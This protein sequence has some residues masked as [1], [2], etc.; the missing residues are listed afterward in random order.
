MCKRTMYTGDRLNEISFPLGG[1]GTGSIGLGGNGRLMD[2]EIFNHPDKGS[3]NGYSH[4]AVK[5]ERDGKVIDARVLNGDVAGALAA[6]GWGVDKRTLAGFPHFRNC[7]FE[8]EFPLATVTLSDPESPLKAQIHA[9]NPFI[10]HHA[11]DSSIPAAF[12]VVTVTNDSQEPLTVS[13]AGSLQNPYHGAINRYFAEN[14]VKGISLTGV[15]ENRESPDY[16]EIVLAT[17]AQDISYQEYWYRGGW[18][19]FLETY[20]RNFTEA[21]PFHNRTYE[22]DLKETRDHATLCARKTLAAGESYSVRYLIA[23]YN[24]IKPDQW[25]QGEEPDQNVHNY[26]SFVYDG[27]KSVALDCFARWDALYA[28]TRRWHDALFASTL[29]EEVLDAVSATSSVLKT[30]TA[31]RID[32]E[33]WFYGWEGLGQKTGSCEGTCTHVWN[34]A[35]VLPFL[36]PD[37][38]RGIREMDFRYNQKP[39]GEMCFRMRIPLGRGIGEHRACVDGQMGGVMKT[40]REWKLSGDTEWLRSVWAPMKKS[41]EYAWNPENLDKWDSGC[42]GVMDGRQHH[43]LDMELFSPSSWLQ[44]F[45]LGALKAAAEMADALG[46]GDAAKYRQ[47]FEQGKKW[48]AENL[49]NGRYFIQK[50]DLTDKN[51]VER[52]GEEAVS[53]YWNE[54]VGQVKYQYGEGCEIDQMVAQWHADIIGLGDLFDPKQV[55]VALQN[56]FRYNFKKDMRHH[57]NTFRLFAINDES[58]AIICEWPEDVVKPAI[59]TTYAQESMH[60]FEYSFAGLLISRGYVQEGLQVV[61]GVRDRYRGDHRNP[62]NEI[63]CGSNYARSMASFALLPLLSGMTFDMVKGELGFKPVLPGDFRCVWSVG[64]AWGNV[65]IGA[66]NELEI[67]EGELCLNSLTLPVTEV[68][69]VLVDGKAVPFTVADGKITFAEKLC[70]REKLQVL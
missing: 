64:N 13:V 9:F 29:P 59:P 60:G 45:Y 3:L 70:I 66:K 55:D 34:Y 51:L 17:D 19:D 58:G 11:K 26:Y 27:A 43:T 33:G 62:W 57:Y 44:G 52:F 50:I 31:I 8:G 1:I 4:F 30:E 56:M 23:W 35:Y 5:A 54:E 53:R 63:E 10:P 14:S 7:T 32:K 18:Y 46:D 15:E 38:E 28:G 39:S 48:C 65:Y 68:K 41:L 42:T 49:F 20:W 67:I 2:W 40:Y 47:L 61:R 22:V 12:F 37:L 24:P 25:K 16:G 21:K 69:Q 6:G 36:F